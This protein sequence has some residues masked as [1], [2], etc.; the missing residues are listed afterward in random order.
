MIRV[1]RKV[2]SVNSAHCNA[3]YRISSSVPCS[4]SPL[5][6]FY[7]RNF[8]RAQNLVENIKELI[9]QYRINAPYGILTKSVKMLKGYKK[10]VFMAVCRADFVID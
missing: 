9:Y 6:A 2:Q 1:I 7:R 3:V 4:L 8:S 10:I 5:A